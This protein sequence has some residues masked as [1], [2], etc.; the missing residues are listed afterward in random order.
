MYCLLIV[1]ELLLVAAEEQNL[2]IIGL[3]FTVSWQSSGPWP[4]A[5]FTCRSMWSPWQPIGLHSKHLEVNEWTC[6]NPIGIPFFTW[7]VTS[8]FSTWNTEFTV[9]SNVHD[10]RLLRFAQVIGT[11]NF[12]LNDCTYMPTPCVQESCPCG[13]SLFPSS[14]GRWCECECR[15]F[16]SVHHT[17]S[18]RNPL[19]G[20]PGAANVG[21]GFNLI[22]P[23]PPF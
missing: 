8:C 18:L 1:S 20:N 23:K 11:C 10:L 22:S 16:W 7:P 17:Y 14:S 13:L 21:R 19:T 15:L 3:C 2:C 6:F 5:T 4:R 9:M 12:G